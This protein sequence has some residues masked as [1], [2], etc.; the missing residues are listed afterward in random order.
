MSLIDPI[1]DHHSEKRLFISRIILAVVVGLALLGIVVARLVQLQVRDY[2]LF[3]AK[4]QGN[5]IRI[6]ALPPTRGLIYD[7]RG[8]ILAENLPAY[9][10]E[11][12]PEQVPDLQDTLARLAAMGL[13]R[14]EDI[15]RFNGLSQ[16]GPRS[17]RSRCVSV[18]RMMR[19]RVSQINGRDSLGSTF[20][21]DWYG[22]IRTVI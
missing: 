17:S 15:P 1:K 21:R 10:L 16:T 3:A 18:Y 7:R 6:A 22:T 13:I 19:S 9:Q 14:T 5:R 2:E 8:R 11:L 4:S 12:I 20:N